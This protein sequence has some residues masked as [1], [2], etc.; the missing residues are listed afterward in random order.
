M[1]KILSLIHSR[2]RFNECH[3]QYKYIR[4]CFGWP[5]L[6]SL[7]TFIEVVKF[8]ITVGRS[9]LSFG[10]RLIEEDCVVSLQ[11]RLSHFAGNDQASMEK[12]DKPNTVRV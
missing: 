5:G 6:S 1:T 2:Y 3:F 8:S 7:G 10:L 11:Q 9:T 4:S 12:N